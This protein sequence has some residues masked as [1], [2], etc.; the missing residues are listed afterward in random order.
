M[1]FSEARRAQF[2]KF[3]LLTSTLGPLGKHEMLPHLFFPS[4]TA[5]LVTEFAVEDQ[6][7]GRTAAYM[8]EFAVKDMPLGRNTLMMIMMMNTMYSAL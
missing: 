5:I 4:K 7:L 2:V 3:T 1:H 6:P 8:P